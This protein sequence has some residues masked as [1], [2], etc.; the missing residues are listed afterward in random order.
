MKKLLMQLA[1]AKF[2]RRLENLPAGTFALEFSR[3]NGTRFNVHWT[4]DTFPEV[5]LE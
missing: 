3:S 5:T 4:V 1:G 2:E